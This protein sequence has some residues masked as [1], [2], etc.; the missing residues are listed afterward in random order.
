MVGPIESTIEGG[1]VE[2]DRR[3]LVTLASLSLATVGLALG[4]LFLID[5]DRYRLLLWAAIVSEGT[6]MFFLA[7]ARR[8]AAAFRRP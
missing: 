7:R 4:L 8:R 6:A 1:A 3:K 2:G 5:P